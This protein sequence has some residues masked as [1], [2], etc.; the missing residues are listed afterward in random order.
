MLT[1]GSIMPAIALHPQAFRMREIIRRLAIEP[2][3]LWID[4]QSRKDAMNFWDF[5]PVEG[6]GVHI[7]PERCNPLV[8]QVRFRDMLSPEFYRQLRWN[9]FRLHFQF[10]MAN[11]KRAPY[12]FFML[13]CGPVPVADWATRKWEVVDKFSPEGMYLEVSLSSPLELER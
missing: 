8:W 12:D 6:V 7:G 10:I 9:I 13:V 3:V 11:D 5:D 1:I 4:C 2:S